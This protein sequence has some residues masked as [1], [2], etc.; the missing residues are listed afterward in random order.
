[1]GQ[2]QI[3]ALK[4]NAQRLERRCKQLEK[5][6][7]D[8]QAVARPSHERAG[9]HASFDGRGSTAFD[10]PHTDAETASVPSISARSHNSQD[11]S[12]SEREMW[13]EQMRLMQ[14]LVGEAKD[15]AR[16]EHLRWT[17]EERNVLIGQLDDISGR[18]ESLNR[19]FRGLQAEYGRVRAESTSL[20]RSCAGL[21]DQ[22]N[23]WQAEAGIQKDR[24]TKANER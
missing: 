19:D 10:R 12:S 15:H 1:M 8:A 22:R 11:V 13:I 3:S 6:L 9:E 24:A 14:R 23:F 17:A 18:F 4:D 7:E 5:E 20:R 2:C 21:Q 16:Q